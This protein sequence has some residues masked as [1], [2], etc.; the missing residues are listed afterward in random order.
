[1]TTQLPTLSVNQQASSAKKILFQHETY[2]KQISTSAAT[3]AGSLPFTLVGFVE[4]DPGAAPLAGVWGC[5]PKLL[6]PSPPQDFAGERHKK[7]NAARA[8]ARERPYNTRKARL[9]RLV[10]CRGGACPRPRTRR[11]ACG[12]FEYFSH[13][14]AKSAG[15][16]PKKPT[17]VNERGVD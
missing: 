9:K 3:G 10:Y 8:T 12:K 14:P 7:C 1:M 11:L 16:V 15:G 13:S 17:P 6:S 5:P 4:A 2:L